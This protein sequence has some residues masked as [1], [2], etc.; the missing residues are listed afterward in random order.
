M[1]PN[2]R[3]QIEYPT[4]YLGTLAAGAAVALIPAQQELTDTDV[5]AW[6]TQSETKL[7]ITDSALLDLA[8]SS[9]HQAS[10]PHLMTLDHTEY[11]PYVSLD[12][13]LAHGQPDANIFYLTSESSAA[14]HDAFLNRTSG[15]TGVVKNVLTSHAHFIATMEGTLGTI[16]AS[17]DPARDVWLSPLSLGFFIN[18]KLHMGLNILLGIPVV[19]ICDG[20]TL[21][22][23]TVD[24]VARHRVTFLF[25]TPPVAARL[26][27]ADLHSVD[28][29]SVKW[30]LT[31]GAPIHENLRRAVS[32]QFGGVPLD[33]EWGTS[34]TMLIAVQTNAESSRRD[35]SSGTLINGMQTKVISTGHNS[36]AELG[37]GQ[38]GEIHVRN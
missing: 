28:V 16:P 15:S 37:A 3:Q 34:E 26:A 6:L 18:A 14:A 4:A 29:C 23:T 21:D 19:L 11:K 30:L 33:L 36:E 10:I 32:R 20:H 31:A 13:L 5:V 8:T 35:G 2:Q 1:N 22:E 17:T 38:A 25:I 7:L 27:R 9:A 24:V 12:E